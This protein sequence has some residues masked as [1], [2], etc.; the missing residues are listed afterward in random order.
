MP[1]MGFGPG[2]TALDAFVVSLLVLAPALVAQDPR[3]PRGIYAVLDTESLINQQ[4]IT[5]AQL[6]PYFDD[7][8]KQLLGNPAIAGLTLQVQWRRLNPNSPATSNPY[9][10]NVVDDAFTQVAAWNAQNPT[11]APKTVQLIVTPGFN[12]PQWM[13][14]QIPSC[15]GLFSKPVTTPS[16]ACGK[17]TFTGDGEMADGTELPLPWNPFYKTSWGVFLAAL[18]AR[19]DPNPAFVSIAVAGPTASSA[20]MTTASK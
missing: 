8:Y 11:A 13:L 9:A 1:T 18:A 15:D 3:R 2:R 16:S 7:L 19:Y 14:A 20:E 10:W 12:S 6:D 5:P 17:A 4:S